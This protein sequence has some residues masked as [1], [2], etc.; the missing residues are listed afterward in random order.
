MTYPMWLRILVGVALLGVLVW[1][2]HQR[3]RAAGEASAATFA[4]RDAF[5]TMHAQLLQHPGWQRLWHAL[6]ARGIVLSAQAAH[7]GAF[8]LGLL[9]LWTD[10][11]DT[12]EPNDPAIRGIR[13]YLEGPKK[14]VASLIL[15]TGEVHVR[16]TGFLEW[17]FAAFDREG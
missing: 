7:Q 3:W 16:D 4:E 6:A 11:G 12:F 9:A 1:K 10:K 5:R 17:P 13:A 8:H 15:A 14:I 2:V